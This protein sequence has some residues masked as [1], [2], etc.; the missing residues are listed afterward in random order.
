M[1]RVSTRAERSSWII[2]GL[3]TLMGGC[4]IV[5]PVNVA[6]GNPV[7]VAAGVFF[8][9]VCAQSHVIY[10][11]PTGKL[12]IIEDA[13]AEAYDAA[14]A[15]IPGNPGIVDNVFIDLSLRTNPFTVN[16]GSADHVIVAGRGLPI[17][18]G[19]TMRAYAAPGT[20]VLYLI[21]G[22]TVAVNTRVSFAG[23]LI[24]VP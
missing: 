2:A 9:E 11:V 18:G 21:G 12:L 14:T 19:R 8:N 16:F 15:S 1:Q 22:C 6:A 23:R 7:N 17:A 5:D 3:L 13:S 20:D 4:T 10:Q 24:D